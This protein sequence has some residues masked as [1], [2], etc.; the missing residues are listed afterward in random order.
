MKIFDA[1]FHIINP[2]YP[3]VPKQG[4]IPS[5]FTTED[6][7]NQLNKIEL[8]GGAVISGSFQ[9]FDQEYLIDALSKLGKDFYGVANIPFDMPDSDLKKLNKAGVRAVRFNLKRGGSEQ[10]KHLEYLSKK[11]YHGFN[12]HTELYLDSKDIQ[13][14]LSTWE[15]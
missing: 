5:G 4:Y 14:W 12:W 9:A 11:L 1:H 10:V 15:L 2:N 7:R 13:P 6:Y 3:L 8:V